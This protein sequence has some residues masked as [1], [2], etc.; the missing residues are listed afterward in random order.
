[1]KFRVGK[2][3]TDAFSILTSLLGIEQNS[4]L[5]YLN[6]CLLEHLVEDLARDKDWIQ[7]IKSTPDAIATFR[8][9]VESRTRSRWDADNI[10]TLYDRVK[11]ASEK[12]YRQPITYETL[13]RLLF[14]SPLECANP[15][16]GKT[17]PEVK[18]HIDHRFPASKGGSSEYENLQFLCEQ[19]NLRKSD[20]LQKDTL[21]LKL[22]SLQPF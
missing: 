15:S 9:R 3:H 1:M 5:D 8:R 13:L 12:H 16:C 6:W 2:A 22:E 11:M 20:K 18:L 19:C 10:I 14:N 7:K 4:L 21:W 17:P